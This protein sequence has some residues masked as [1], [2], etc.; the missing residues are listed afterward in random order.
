MSYFASGPDNTPQYIFGPP[1]SFRKAASDLSPDVLG[2]LPLVPLISSGGDR[3][4]PA[5]L[6]PPEVGEADVAKSVMLEIARVVWSK[7]GKPE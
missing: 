5:I 6:A 2:E 7:V 3:G 4:M 1:T